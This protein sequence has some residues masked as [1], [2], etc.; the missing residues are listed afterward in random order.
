[1]GSDRGLFLT[2]PEQMIHFLFTYHVSTP[3]GATALDPI[4]SV[5]VEAASPSPGLHI[6]IPCL[7]DLEFTAGK[8]KFST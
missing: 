7:C 3:G 4:C 2:Q 1:M 8:D 5:S 6:V